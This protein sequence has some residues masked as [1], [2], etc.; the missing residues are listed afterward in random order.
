MAAGPQPA[1]DAAIADL[2]AAIPTATSSA[3]ARSSNRRS[4]SIFTISTAPHRWPPAPSAPTCSNGGGRDPRRRGRNGGGAFGS[5]G[6][7]PILCAHREGPC[8]ARTWARAARGIIAAQFP[9]YGGDG[10]YVGQLLITRNSDQLSNGDTAVVV[11]QGGYLIAV[12]DGF[13]RAPVAS[14]AA[15]RRRRHALDDDPQGTGAASSRR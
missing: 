9:G 8:G 2:S 10:H 7:P 12:V 5:L 6:Q 3:A 4:T 15:R 11:R 1:P 13:R 14:R